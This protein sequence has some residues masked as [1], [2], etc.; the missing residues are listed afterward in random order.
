MY[1]YTTK[2]NELL[3]PQAGVVVVVVVEG[4]LA[5]VVLVVASVVVVLVGRCHGEKVAD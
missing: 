3:S 4:D 5:V 2:T 1:L